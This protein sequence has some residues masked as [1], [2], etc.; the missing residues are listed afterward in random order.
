MRKK[1]VGQVLNCDYQLQNKNCNNSHVK[2]TLFDGYTCRGM[3]VC[4]NMETVFNREIINEREKPKTTRKKPVEIRTHEQDK[5]F[6]QLLVTD[7]N[8]TNHK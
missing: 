1:A 5:T 2:Q 8:S 3:T 7:S 4:V 6:H